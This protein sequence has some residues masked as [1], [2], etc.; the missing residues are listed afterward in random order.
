MNYRKLNRYSY[1]ENIIELP[2]VNICLKLIRFSE[3]QNVINILWSINTHMKGLFFPL[4]ACE[5]VFD[6]RVSFWW[7][8]TVDDGIFRYCR[9]D[10]V[11]VYFGSSN[12]WFPASSNTRHP[13]NTCLIDS[14]VP[15]ESHDGSL[16]FLSINRGTRAIRTQ[17]ILDRFLIIILL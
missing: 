11:P 15:R 16:Y 8:V 12:Y 2:V 1:Y 14:E 4:P 6:S 10:S 3:K 9:S 17:P 5:I 7:I 13:V